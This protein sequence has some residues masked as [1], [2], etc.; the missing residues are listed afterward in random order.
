MRLAIRGFCFQKCVGL[1]LTK[2]HRR[3]ERVITHPQ[4]LLHPFFNF[5]FGAR[6]DYPIIAVPSSDNSPSS[7]GFTPTFSSAS[8]LPLDQVTLTSEFNFKIYLRLFGVIIDE[9]MKFT[10]AAS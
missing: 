6:N 7:G 5:L 8:D 2:Q 4:I 9:P 3:H 10:V 1:S